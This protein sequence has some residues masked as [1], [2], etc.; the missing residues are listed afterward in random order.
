M[1]HGAAKDAVA[2]RVRDVAVCYSAEACDLG[3]VRAGVGPAAQ[4]AYRSKGQTEL[5]AVWVAHVAQVVLEAQQVL[6]SFTS[7]SAVLM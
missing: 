6:P 7:H 3:S 2:E 5:V 4:A 1:A